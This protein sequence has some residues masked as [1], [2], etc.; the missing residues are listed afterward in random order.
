[1]KTQTEWL[2]LEKYLQEIPL[3]AEEGG[4]LSKVSPCK[5]IR[6]YLKKDWGVTQV[7]ECLPSKCKT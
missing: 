2:G 4:A 3:E 1:L 5:S 6:T 7:V